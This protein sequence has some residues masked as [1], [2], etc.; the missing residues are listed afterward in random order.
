MMGVILSYRFNKENLQQDHPAPIKEGQVAHMV[1]PIA[2][3]FSTQTDGGYSLTFLD[4]IAVD[5]WHAQPTNGY[6]RHSVERGVTGVDQHKGGYVLIYASLADWATWGLRR[7]GEI[8]KV[9]NCA[10]GLDHG[11]WP[12]MKEALDALPGASPPAGCAA[13]TR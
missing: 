5:R 1:R 9:W 8:I 10:T 13:N 12:T 6:R 4:C 3:T 7:C 2:D 11:V